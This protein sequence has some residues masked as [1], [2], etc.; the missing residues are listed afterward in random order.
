MYSYQYRSLNAQA[1]EIRLLQVQK[2][3]DESTSITI[4][5]R[6]ANLDDAPRFY[7]LSYTWGD[8]TPTTQITIQDDNGMGDVSVRRN[9]YEFLME[10]RQSTKYWSSA[11]IW[12]DQICI[13]QNDHNERCHQVGQMQRLYSTSQATLVWPWSWSVDSLEVERIILKAHPIDTNQAISDAP[14]HRAIIEANCLNVALENLLDLLTYSLY[15]KFLTSPY[16]TRQWII[17]EIVLARE[18]FIVISKE[19]FRQ[20]YIVAV[21]NFIRKKLHVSFMDFRGAY[22]CLERLETLNMYHFWKWAD[23]IGMNKRRERHWMSWDR[24]LRLSEG[25]YCTVPLDKVYGVMGLLHEDFQILPDYNISEA[26]LLRSMLQKQMS[27]TTT[28]NTDRWR[29]VYKVLQAWQ[30]TGLQQSVGTR[31]DLDIAKYGLRRRRKT[32]KVVNL[33]LKELELHEF[34]YTWEERR[35]DW[36][37]YYRYMMPKAVRKLT[38]KGSG[39]SL[40]PLDDESETEQEL[41]ERSVDPWK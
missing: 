21:T 22:D 9:L 30:C 18:Y 20:D 37:Y 38:Y 12:I 34:Q 5:L 35:A 33:A 36:R 10:A 28:D 13:N 17:Q 15:V 24:A 7:A 39:L 14:T 19:L 25:A 26:E 27:M 6:H 2:T 29:N 3:S 40:E 1:R 23:R 32:F 4:S 11:W 16:W 31:W 41:Y 8:E